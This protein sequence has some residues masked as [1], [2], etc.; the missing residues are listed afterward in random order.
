MKTYVQP[1]E[2]VTLTAPYDV[3]SGAG[4]KVGQV[5]AVATVDALSGVSL[6]GQRTGVVDIAKVSAQ[7]WTQGALIYWDNS[8]KL[9]TTTATSN[10]L[11]GGAAAAAAN[12]S[13]TGRVILSGAPRADG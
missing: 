13:A 2:S 11:I 6:V 5:F 9:A 4:F 8:A 12:P 3:L 7:A 10:L 1:G